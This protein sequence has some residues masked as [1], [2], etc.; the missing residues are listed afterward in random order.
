M[1]ISYTV[2]SA[3]K[4]LIG[5]MKIIMFFITGV[6]NKRTGNQLLGKNWGMKISS[7]N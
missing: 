4:E 2:K 3:Y 6:P 7:Y 5:T 1:P